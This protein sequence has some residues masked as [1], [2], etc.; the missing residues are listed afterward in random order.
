M[1]DD[2]ATRPAEADAE[3]EIDVDIDPVCGALVDPEEADQRSLALEYEGRR[4]V[5]C[6]DGCRALFEEA[7]IR[8]AAAGRSEP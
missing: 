2:M 1:T 4:Y 6:G 7:P 5:F 8:F 3:I